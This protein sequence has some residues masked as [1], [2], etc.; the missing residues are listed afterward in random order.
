MDLFVC[1]FLESVMA[2]PQRDHTA[3]DYCVVFRKLCG[4]L[5]K[6]R[7]ELRAQFLVTT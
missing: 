5:K 1:C 7:G 3:M 6:R 2:L 4:S